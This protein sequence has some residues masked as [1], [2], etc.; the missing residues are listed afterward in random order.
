MTKASIT[1]QAF[2]ILAVK[3][4]TFC[5][6]LR[7]SLGVAVKTRNYTKMKNPGVVSTAWKEE[8]NVGSL[9]VCLMSL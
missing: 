5:Q 2:V 8:N 9:F 1:G 6:Y 4:N 3:R 7:N